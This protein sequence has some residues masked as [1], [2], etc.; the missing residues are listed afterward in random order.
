M[1]LMIDP[2]RKSSDIIFSLKE[3]HFAQTI[4]DQS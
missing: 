3:M 4:L 1:S 2:L